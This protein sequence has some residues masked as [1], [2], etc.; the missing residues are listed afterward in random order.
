MWNGLFTMEGR[1]QR[2]LRQV[3]PGPLRAYFA[4]PFPERS[5]DWRRVDFVALDFE[6]T[7]TD[8]NRHE[9]L[10]VGMVE[11]RDGC[12]RLDSARHYLVAPDGSVPERSAVIHQLTDDELAEGRPLKEVLPEVLGR[13]AGRVLLCHHAAVETGFLDAACRRLYGAAFITLVTDTEWLI[14]RWLLQR[15]Q[16]LAP[17]ALRLHALRERFNLPRYKAHDALIDALATAELFCAFAAHRDLGNDPS[18]RQFLSRG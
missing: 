7:G 12:I 13:L 16:S 11:L 15:N 18:L 6:T 1:R 8:P 5:A 9:I 17:G 3:P 10:S 14:G 2:M 4:V